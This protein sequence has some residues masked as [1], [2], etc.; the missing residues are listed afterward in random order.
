MSEQQ[1]AGQLFRGYTTPETPR[2]NYTL[3]Y[4]PRR[5]SS[6]RNRPS[7]LQLHPRSMSAGNAP[8]STPTRTLYRREI[9]TGG[10]RSAPFVRPTAVADSISM[11]APEREAIKPDIPPPPLLKKAPGSSEDISMSPHK[12]SVVET[13]R[14]DSAGS[15]TPSVLSTDEEKTNLSVRL[16]PHSFASKMA[17]GLE[18]IEAETLPEQ[19]P[20]IS[21]NASFQPKGILRDRTSE[22]LRFREES[23]KS[24]EL[25]EQR[26]ERRL[27]KIA[28]LYAD[29][30][31]FCGT[32]DDISYGILT[33]FQ[34]AQSLKKQRF[35]SMVSSHE[36][37][38]VKW[39]DD[40][41]VP[42]CS[43]C[44][45][46]CADRT[47]FSLAVGRHHCRLCGRIVCSSPRLPPILQT[48][49]TVCDEPCSTLCNADPKT[50]TI[51]ELPPCAP[52]S[53]PQLS[54]Y[55]ERGLHAFRACADCRA[56]LMRMQYHGE[57]DRQTPLTRLYATLVSLQKKIEEAIPDLHEMIMGLQ[58]ERRKGAYATGDTDLGEDTVQ[59][60]K[61]LLLWFSQYDS[62]AKTICDLKHE[63][64]TENQVQRAIFARAILFLQKN[65]R[66]AC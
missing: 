18:G 15:R 5:G 14:Q 37:T 21:P 35:R 42:N 56:T 62:L 46:V 53:G 55:E 40:R 64:S 47:P 22:F 13:Q 65:V 54:A 34:S 58:I 48:G 16:H 61:N 12:N 39:Q 59:A 38:I 19:A 24:V 3:K 49:V 25:E 50:M 6:S 23:R 57:K 44:K 17:L 1:S 45:C 27:E 11:P 30:E 60:R 28:L 20:N 43:I 32:T 63:T 8:P 2:P 4:E 26:L 29:P 66:K 52:Q 36:Q 10:T 31:K 51:Q 33:F 41:A 7:P 9:S